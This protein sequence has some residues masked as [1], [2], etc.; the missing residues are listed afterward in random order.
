LAALDPLPP[1]E[2]EDGAGVAAGVVEDE[3]SFAGDEPSFADELPPD[4]AV[5][6]AVALLRLS[7]R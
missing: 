2:D 5:S 6:D 4:E 3:L 1:E 7:V